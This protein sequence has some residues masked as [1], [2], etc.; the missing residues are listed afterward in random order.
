MVS[1]TFGLVILQLHPWFISQLGGL[2]LEKALTQAILIIQMLITAT[3]PAELHLNACVEG[4]SMALLTLSLIS[5][6]A[7][8]IH[9]T[10]SVDRL[11]EVSLTS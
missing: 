10:H 2:A 9:L 4:G 5:L 6:T 7:S 3:S 1:L 11:T 8:M